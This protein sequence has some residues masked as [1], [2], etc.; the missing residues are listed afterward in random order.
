[1]DHLLVE[2]P[3]GHLQL[4]ATAKGICC[5]TFENSKCSI[6]EKVQIQNSHL[7]LLKEELAKFFG[8]ELKRFTVQ[9][10]AK[11]T[12]F[13]KTV[14]NELPKISHGQT[15]TYGEIASRI[16]KPKAYRAVGGANNRNPL[17]IV[18]PCH[19]VVGANQSLVGYA[20]DLW[21]KQW[22]L[23]H[24]GAVLPLSIS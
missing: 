16:G 17:P 11:G 9:L 13:Q 22:L 5:I 8:G 20:G 2:S 18:V 15:A 21:R 10:D 23:E 3:I 19:R 6:G 14:W 4:S 12:S 24:E 1:M 7:D